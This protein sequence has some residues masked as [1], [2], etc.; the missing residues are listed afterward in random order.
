MTCSQQAVTERF[1]VQNSRVLLGWES[2]GEGICPGSVVRPIMQP[3]HGCDPGSNPGQ[4][5]SNGRAVSK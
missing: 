3:C 4:G 1:P 5:V 2:P